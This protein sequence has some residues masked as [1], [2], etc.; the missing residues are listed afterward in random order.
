[1]DYSL[2]IE[3]GISFLETFLGKTKS[4][5]PV[6]IAQSLEATIAALQAHKDDVLTKANFE[7][8]RG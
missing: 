5:L 7:A 8:Q 4:R 1:M 3:L 6:E 2:I